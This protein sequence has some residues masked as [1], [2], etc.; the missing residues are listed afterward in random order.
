[1]EANDRGTYRKTREGG[2]LGI[3]IVAGLLALTYG[4]AP[5]ARHWYR[6]GRLPNGGRR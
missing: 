4:L 5:G 1:M 2:A 3:G 6:H